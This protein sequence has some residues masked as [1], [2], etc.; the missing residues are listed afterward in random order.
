M[1]NVIEP[2][3]MTMREFD[4]QYDRLIFRTWSWSRFLRG[5]C[6]KLSFPGFVKW[7]FFV[8]LLII[9]LRW[10]RRE[11]YRA[12]REKTT[13]PAP[14]CPTSEAVLVS[15]LQKPQPTWTDVKAKL[16]HFDRAVSTVRHGE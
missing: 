8:R 4:R 3:H 15:R 12:A 1:Y 16:A 6:G 14:L 9:Q 11:I 10:K 5:K 2:V 7:W 13:A